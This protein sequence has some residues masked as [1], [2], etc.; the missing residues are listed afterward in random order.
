MKRPDPRHVLR[1]NVLAL[2]HA[3]F[4]QENLSRLA[5]E[6]KIGPGSCTRIKEAATSVG[7][8][9]ID[10]IASRYDYDAW[11]LLVPGFDPRNPPV[12]K[13]VSPEERQLYDR[14]VSA[15]EALAKLKRDDP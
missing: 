14:L 12:L 7:L 9:V 13:P 2:M 11:Q 15:A 6:A 3:R 4:G 1:D 8:E 10:K 5:R